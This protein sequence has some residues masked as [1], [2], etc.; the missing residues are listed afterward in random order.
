METEKDL[1]LVHFWLLHELVLSSVLD[2]FIYSFVKHDASIVNICNYLE[3]YIIE[4][5]TYII[6][7]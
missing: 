1:N 6:C 7:R 4:L 2:D 5:A 3:H